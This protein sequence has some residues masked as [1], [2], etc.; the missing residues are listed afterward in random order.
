[1]KIINSIKEE[2][3]AATTSVSNNME[4]FK[5]E[6][7]ELQAGI[8]LKVEAERRL[9]CSPIQTEVS[10]DYRFDPA[11]TNGNKCRLY[12]SYSD[13]NHHIIRRATKR[14]TRTPSSSSISK[15]T[16]PL[17]SLP[18]T[19]FIIFPSKTSSNHHPRRHQK[20]IYFKQSIMSQ[21]LVSM[22]LLALVALSALEIFQLQ[23]QLQP[24]VSCTEVAAST[25]ISHQKP[26]EGLRQNTQQHPSLQYAP[27]GG[28][29]LQA[30][31]DVIQ[32]QGELITRE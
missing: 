27:T 5:G 8:E 18:L 28:H 19:K 1:M 17:S 21:S 16:S 20:R 12:D 15:S 30:T 29:A 3:K 7:N 26:A 14:A 10:L 6:D 24:L 4:Q 31:N 2:E 11:A 13:N 32:S 22:V 9:V 25:Q 23:H